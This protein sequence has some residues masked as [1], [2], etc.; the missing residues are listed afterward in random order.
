MNLQFHH[1]GF[2]LFT[3]LAAG[4]ISLFALSTMAATS[5][6]PANP[7]SNAK[8]RAV[9]KYFQSLAD[10]TD[11]RVLSGQFTDFGKGAGLRLMNQIHEKSGR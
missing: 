3:G 9:L 6:E 11:K 10:R 4:L 7:Q 5:L 8:T 2:R 1:R